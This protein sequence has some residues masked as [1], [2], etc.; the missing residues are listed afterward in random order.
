LGVGEFA[1]GLGEQGGAATQVVGGVSQMR[2][3]AVADR[4]GAT[5]D[6]SDQSTSS[7]RTAAGVSPT[8]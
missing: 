8:R 1:G 5:G 7:T 4:L 6:V 2:P 3:V